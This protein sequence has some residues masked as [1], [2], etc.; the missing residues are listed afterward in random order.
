MTSY[1][2]WFGDEQKK[3]NNNHRVKVRLY[4]KPGDAHDLCQVPWHQCFCQREEP[5]AIQLDI[6]VFTSLR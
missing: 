3:K 5:S 6:R 4:R 1:L 2:F